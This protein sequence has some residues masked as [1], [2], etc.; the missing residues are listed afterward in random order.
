MGVACHR[1]MITTDASLSG[2][3]AVFEGRPPCGV[4]TGKYLAWH[5][6]S[7]EMRAVYLALVQFLPFLAHSHV[8]VK[9]A[10]MSVVSHINRHGGS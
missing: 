2:W 4:W 8:T 5:I 6:N 1:Q 9:A 7:L 3:G 10:N